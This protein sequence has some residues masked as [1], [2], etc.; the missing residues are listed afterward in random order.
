MSLACPRSGATLSSPRSAATGALGQAASSASVRP[1]VSRGAS[2]S[3]DTTT[4]LRRIAVVLRRRVGITGE[5]QD[6]DAVAAAA[7]ASE[8]VARYVRAGRVAELPQL[9]PDLRRVLLLLLLAPAP[10]AAT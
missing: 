1:G 5:P 8:L 10:D 2:L 7:L 4:P 9:H 6:I 3:A